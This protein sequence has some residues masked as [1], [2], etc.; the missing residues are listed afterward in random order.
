MLEKYFKKE[1]TLKKYNC[2]IVGTYL[3]RFI[4][5]LE[6]QG[7]CQTTIRRHVREVFK[8]ASWAEANK[9]KINH[10]DR[11]SLKKFSFHLAKFGSPYYQKGTHNHVYQSA[12]VFVNFLEATGK[13]GFKDPYALTQPQKLFLEFREWMRTERGTLDSTLNNYRSPIIDLIQSLGDDPRLFNGKNVREFLI[14]DAN[15]FSRT[16][17]KNS[18][19]LG[20]RANDVSALHFSDIIWSDSTLVVSGKNRRETRLSLPQEVGDAI[21]HYLK[22]G[23]PHIISDYVFIT[24]VAPFKPITRQV[25]GK[26]VVRAINRT[27]ISSPNQGAHLF[28]HSL[29]SHMLRDGLSL[30]AI[31]ALLRH[32]SIETTTIYAKVDVNLLKEV[33]MPW[34]EVF[35]C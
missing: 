2:G 7:Y 35:P 13:V 6:K 21:L 22:H 18:A 5:W 29:A 9:L 25:V 23:R 8:F 24:T 28:R 17:L 11:L 12:N 34:P 10:L 4:V 26:T 15:C 32:A 31:G 16:K 3:K 27:G 33:A 30:P 19:I 1:L 14:R 20:L